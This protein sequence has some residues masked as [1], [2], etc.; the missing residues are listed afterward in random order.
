MAASQAPTNATRAVLP[1]VLLKDKLCVWPDPH[2][3]ERE[4]DESVRAALSLSKQSILSASDRRQ[5]CSKRSISMCYDQCSHCGL[6][7]FIVS[8][9]M[10]HVQC[11]DLYLE[12]PSS[13]ACSAQ[14]DRRGRS[15]LLYACF[16]GR[17]EV[18]QSMLRCNVAVTHNDLE[19]WTPLHAL[20]A[21]IYRR[22]LAERAIRLM[23]VE[24][25]GSGHIASHSSAVSIDN[26]ACCDDDDDDDDDD[27]V[28]F[29]CDLVADMVDAS[30]YENRLDLL[31]E[32]Y[33][34]VTS[35]AE[36]WGALHIA[37]NGGNEELVHTLLNA[38]SVGLDDDDDDD[39]DEGNLIDGDDDDGKKLLSSSWSGGDASLSPPS[40]GNSDSSWRKCKSVDG[41]P[42]LSASSSSMAPPSPMRS[43][44]FLD[45]P[46]R[47]GRTP[48]HLAVCPAVFRD[49]MAVAKVVECLVRSSASIECVDVDRRTPLHIA[50][51]C[52]HHIACSILLADG[53]ADVDSQ[54]E[55]GFTPLH[56]A[57]LGGHHECVNVLALGGGGGGIDNGDDGS[58]AER[59]ADV[60]AVDSLYRTPLHAA[61]SACH[62]G[63]VAVCRYLLR[64]GAHPD[65]VDS[66]N[67]TPLFY[68]AMAVDDVAA[69]QCAALLLETDASRLAEDDLGRI[70][71]HYACWHGN[72]RVAEQLASRDAACARDAR[73]QRTPLHAAVTG[74]AGIGTIRCV[75]MLLNLEPRVASMGDVSG[76]TALMLAVKADMPAMVRALLRAIADSDST[77][78]EA[79]FNAVERA[80][81][82]ID[83][84]RRN[85]LH[86]AAMRPCSPETVDA[87]LSLLGDTVANA[88]F[89]GVDMH[90]NS[91]WHAL[92]AS[93]GGGDG[94]DDDRVDAFIDTLCG[95][96]GSSASSTLAH[97][98]LERVNEAQSTPLLAAAA[99]GNTALVAAFAEHGARIGARSSAG[100]GVW[101]LA[102]RRGAVSTLRWLAEHDPDA[103]GALDEL[104]AL[105]YSPLAYAVI[106]KHVDATRF[107]I[108]A[109]AS[110]DAVC[111]VP[112]ALQAILTKHC[113]RAPPTLVDAR[114]EA[115]LRALLARHR[116]LAL[117]RDRRSGFYPLHQATWL[118]MIGAVRALLS[119]PCV[120][121]DQL[122]LLSRHR[123]SALHLALSREQTVGSGAG[124]AEL[125]IDA[126]RDESELL[127]SALGAADSRGRTPL[128]CA[129]FFGHTPF[130]RVVLE[131]LDADVAR[132][133]F[134]A[135]DKR[136][137]TPLLAAV[138]QNQLGVARLLLDAVAV[139][140]LVAD[141]HGQTALHLAA[142][143]GHERLCALLL[144][145]APAALVAADKA[146]RTP[147]H[148][149]AL[150]D[151][152]ACVNVIVD[153]NPAVVDIVDAHGLTPLSI[154]ENRTTTPAAH[155]VV[156]LLRSR[157]PPQE[158]QVEA[159]Q[160]EPVEQVEQAE[161]AQTAVLTNATVAC[162]THHRASGAIQALLPFIVLLLSSMRFLSL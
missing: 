93:V 120:A 128:H 10:G 139:D 150:R 73:D 41:W 149:A 162:H 13:H 99:R 95:A 114:V 7:A 69:S 75:R 18:V 8:A 16:N 118:R 94:D 47:W 119:A 27:Y 53:G 17:L 134:D 70:A 159:G 40:S 22:P 37:A 137:A 21:A 50:S 67:R 102:A 111:S 5:L 91:V 32:E 110:V 146:G 89:E 59:L 98:E 26:G 44:S 117:Y 132:R 19:G 38:A 25:G 85:C 130:L 36:Q 12:H 126:L 141:K 100:R 20:C 23:N 152:L 90:G 3:E 4:C 148:H 39:D 155:D 14:C 105:G 63:H 71:L 158:E 156:E 72:A 29:L 127:A 103:C 42:S 123:Q 80:V 65:S 122:Q 11:V 24:A 143:N 107:L 68:A 62:V 76:A 96:R 86:Y 109:G 52:G 54:D 43:L 9:C 121:I 83:R 151:R 124:I 104:D 140:A 55:Q 30:Q 142:F 51:A 78:R 87:L 79:E 35:S 34:Y 115:V 28:S 129:A 112:G 157:T 135:R 66:A 133:L 81:L 58:D 15:A 33:C 108:D 138:M 56:L 31:S 113:G 131:R 2:V 154:A 61:A 77:E 145:A 125:M 1:S 97:V 57:A 45:A 46:D 106:G 84:R 161:V 144:A 88:L 92:A 101:H 60:E 116:Q 147:L 64:A 153:A 74:D 6:S 48:L 136:G 160:E 82:A 49:G